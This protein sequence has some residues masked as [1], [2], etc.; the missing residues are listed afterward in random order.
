[1][2]SSWKNSLKN[3][4]DHRSV[5]GTSLRK[6]SSGKK[7]LEERDAGGGGSGGK[8]LGFFMFRDGKKT[9]TDCLRLRLL[10]DGLK[11]YRKSQAAPCSKGGGRWDTKSSWVVPNGGGW[12]ESKGATGMK[13]RALRCQWEGK[14][15]RW[16]VSEEPVQALYQEMLA[17]R[18]LDVPSLG[19]P[20]KSAS[21]SRALERKVRGA[22]LKAT[23]VEELL[24]ARGGM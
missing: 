18:L 11:K 21:G 20:L 12:P 6:A 8:R 17:S 2:Q 16:P 7:A 14:Q 9:Y 4:P 22:H 5:V 24:P 3:L 13:V 15:V 23:Q 1:V 19:R 10:G